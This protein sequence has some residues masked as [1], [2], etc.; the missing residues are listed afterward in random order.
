M[1]R[2]GEHVSA[3]QGGERLREREG[4]SHYCCQLLIGGGGEE[5]EYDDRKNSEPLSIYYLHREF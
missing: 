4:G 1:A 3:M 2:E 5:T